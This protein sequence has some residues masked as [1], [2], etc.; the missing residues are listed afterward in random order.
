MLTSP[1]HRGWRALL[2]LPIVSLLG[3][4]PGEDNLVVHNAT[5]EPL[6]VVFAWRRWQQP[7]GA[8]T[9]CELGAP[10]GTWTGSPTSMFWRLGGP[11]WHE[12][13]V[14]DR[15]KCEATWTLAPNTSVS[16]SRGDVCADH[17]PSAAKRSVA[18]TRLA[19]IEITAPGID[20][21]VSD[22]AAVGLFR[23]VGRQFCALS[24]GEARS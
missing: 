23:R 1:A 11:T 6:K 22:W 19:R 3:G 17:L 20:F 7:D 18:S 12:R 21:Q 13:Y 10:L 15:E 14:M 9:K 2:F 8:L 5:A 4:C 16:V 24:F